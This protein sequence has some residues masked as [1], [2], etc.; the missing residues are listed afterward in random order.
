METNQNT[1]KQ[2]QQKAK[3][4]E[5]EKSLKNYKKSELI[6][7][8]CGVIDLP[9]EKISE[10]FSAVCDL[11]VELSFSESV[12]H[13][14]T[15]GKFIFEPTKKR[16]IWNPK[17]EKSLIYQNPK[18]TFRISHKLRSRLRKEYRRNCYQLAELNNLKKDDFKPPKKWNKPSGEQP[19]E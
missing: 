5:H 8:L 6:D 4:R 14:P 10:V 18:V 1:S 3:R 7:M 19:K 16:K 17:E 11:L 13:I 15:F 12:V 2:R 9:K